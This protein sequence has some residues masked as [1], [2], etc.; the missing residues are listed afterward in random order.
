MVAVLLADSINWNF[1][2]SPV[3][4]GR[5]NTYLHMLKEMQP[6]QPINHGRLWTLMKDQLRHDS[7]ALCKVAEAYTLTAD[8]IDMPNINYNVDFFTAMSE[9]N[10]GRF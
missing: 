8:I 9:L 6:H 5:H 3:S 10:I 2:S 4:E 7:F 1:G